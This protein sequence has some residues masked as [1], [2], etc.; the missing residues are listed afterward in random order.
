MGPTLPAALPDAVPTMELSTP[1]SAAAPAVP[2]RAP[3]SATLSYRPFYSPYELQA[4]IR[5]QAGTVKTQDGWSVRVEMSSQRVEMARQ[6]ACGYIDR[7]GARLG[8]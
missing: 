7:V 2:S 4:L 6:L 5:L 3:V 1:A 8:L